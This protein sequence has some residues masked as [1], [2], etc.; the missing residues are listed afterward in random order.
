MAEDTF[1]ERLRADIETEKQMLIDVAE[2]R[3]Q[4]QDV[5]DD[6]KARRRT[7][8]S[9]LKKLGLDDPNV[10]EDLWLWYGHYS[11]ASNGLNTNQARREH[12]IRSHQ[13]LMHALE[14]LEDRGLGTGIE[15][16]ETGLGGC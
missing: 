8:R 13:P 10:W 4:I 6:Y 2:F 12:V 1:I 15:I 5:N 16:P 11:Q 3:A 9:G 14:N 7:V